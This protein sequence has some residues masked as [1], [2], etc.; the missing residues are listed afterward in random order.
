MAMIA[1]CLGE[2]VGEPRVREIVRGTDRYVT[3]DRITIEEKTIEE[4]NIEEKT[5]EEEPQREGERGKRGSGT[6]LSEDT[7][8]YL[9]LS[10]FRVSSL[11]VLSPHL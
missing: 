3:S 7:F 11:L 4:T 5:K 1:W 6:S 10:F 2:G 9:S 8:L